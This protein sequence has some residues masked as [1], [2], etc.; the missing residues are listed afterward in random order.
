[1]N[2]YDIAYSPFSF[3]PSETNTENYHK[4]IHTLD[5]HMEQIKSSRWAALIKL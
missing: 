4:I 5:V 2:T 1:M 3:Y